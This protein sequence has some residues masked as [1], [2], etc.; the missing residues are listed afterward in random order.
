[1]SKT[2]KIIDEINI[3]LENEWTHEQRDLITRMMNN[4]KSYKSLIP[5][6]F[7]DDIFFI[8]QLF[9]DMKIKYEDVL[10]EKHHI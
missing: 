6:C 5:N 10:N 8:I 4:L 9:N 1:M 3:L 2:Q 7:K